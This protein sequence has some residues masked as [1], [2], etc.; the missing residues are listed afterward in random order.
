M[1]QSHVHMTLCI[2]SCNVFNTSLSPPGNRGKGDGPWEETGRTDSREQTN[3]PR[4]QTTHPE[5]LCWGGWICF[6][7]SQ[8]SLCSFFLEISLLCL[9]VWSWDLLFCCLTRTCSVPLSWSSS[10][11]R[12]WRSAAMSPSSTCAVATTMW[13]R[14]STWRGKCE[15]RRIHTQ[16][17][18]T[19]TQTWG[20]T[21]ARPLKFNLRRIR[22][23]VIAGSSC[24]V[25]WLK[26]RKLSPLP[27]LFPSLH[28]TPGSSIKLNPSERTYNRWVALLWDEYINLSP[29]LS[30]SVFRSRKDSSVALDASKY[31]ALVKTLSKSGRVEGKL[32]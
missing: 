25:D 2:W 8:N 6:N 16:R 15:W 9:Y 31:I 24:S 7:A 29:S 18:S 10:M 23:D 20:S 13:R 17:R 26:H 11:R 5:S 12:R 28:L 22:G 19:N 14:R 21:A 1:C 30:L 4:S 3:R 27:P 32:L